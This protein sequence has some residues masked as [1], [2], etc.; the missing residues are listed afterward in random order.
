MLVV[1]SGQSGCQIAEDLREAGRTVYLSTGRTGWFPRRYRDKDNVR[2]RDE[3]GFFETSVD[4]LAS[5]ADRLAP[6]PI[7]TGKDGGHDLNLRTL[8]KA[9]VILAGRFAGA[10][11]SQVF[12]AGDLDDNLRRS[13]DVAHR[14]MADIDE[15]VRR[16]GESAPTD[17]SDFFFAPRIERVDRLD[18]RKSRVTT[19]VWAIGYDLDFGWVELPVFDEY[20]YPIQRRGV[21]NEPGLAFVGLHWMHTRKSGLIWGVGDDAAH[22]VSTLVGAAV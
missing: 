21:T 3:M 16:R 9:G 5:L 6:V 14:L 18:L 2:W 19:I 12:F 20:G 13:D 7:Q 11:G 1:G 10:D 4:T 22:V 17:G 8:A 15:Y